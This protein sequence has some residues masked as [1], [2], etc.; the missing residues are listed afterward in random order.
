MPSLSEEIIPAYSLAIVALLK[1]LSQSPS[2]ISVA[3]LPPAP[4]N[5]IAIHKS[6]ENGEII[7]FWSFFVDKFCFWKSSD[8]NCKMEDGSL[9]DAIKNKVHYYYF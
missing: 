7:M 1:S 5:V 8:E 6:I 2:A 9:S 3:V 4:I